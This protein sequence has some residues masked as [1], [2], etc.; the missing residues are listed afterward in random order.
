M[1]DDSALEKEREIVI[2]LTEGMELL[3]ARVVAQQAVIEELLPG[4]ATQL[5]S[6][7]ETALLPTVREHFA[8][9]ID[10]FRG[11]PLSTS[12]PIDWNQLVCDLVESSRNVPPPPE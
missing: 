8:E 9:L 11:N 7:L 10:V 1:N 2:R 4:Q 6:E 5:V 12:P 3:T